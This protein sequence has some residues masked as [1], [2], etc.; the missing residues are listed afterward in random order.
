LSNKRIGVD[1]DGTLT[2]LDIIVDI[3][4]RE[5]GKDLQTNNI[6]QYDVGLC[7]GL[8]KE[9]SG[10]IWRDFTGEMIERSFCGL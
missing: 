8:S 2:T 9:D 6:T 10:K 3:F 5:T 7:Y 4:N 1:I